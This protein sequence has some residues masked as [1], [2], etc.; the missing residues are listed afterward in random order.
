MPLLE[1]Y[2]VGLA[3]IVL[4]GPVFF[5]LL[6]ITLQFG[7]RSGLIVAFGI[8]VSDVIAVLLCAFGAAPYLQNPDYLFYFGLIGGVLLIS[9]GASFILKPT[10]QFSQDISLKNKDYIGFFIKGFL[11]NFV[12]PFVFLVWISIIGLGTKKFGFNNS[13]AL[14]MTGALLGIWTTDTLKALFAH[15]IQGFL[16]PDILSKLYRLIGFLL[17]GFGVRMIYQTYVGIDI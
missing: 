2:I 6:Q 16:K 17:V 7:V 1:G 15:R 14:Y 10:L 3:L 8:V 9:F 5:T 4:I 11:V 13:L 12:N